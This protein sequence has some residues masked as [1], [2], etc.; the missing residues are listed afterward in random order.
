MQAQPGEP[1]SEAQ[2]PH[3]K[4]AAEALKKEVLV[5]EADTPKEFS[6]AFARLKDWRADAMVFVETGLFLSHRKSLIEEAEPLG[7]RE[8]LTTVCRSRWIAILWR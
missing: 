8:Q 2:L 1:A 6:P 7:H 3:I 4:K 5:V